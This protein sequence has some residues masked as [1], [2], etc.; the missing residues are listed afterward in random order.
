[1]LIVA[2]LKEEI[3][4]VLSKMQM[5]AI[6]HLKPATLYRGKIFQKEINFLVTGV[7]KNRMEEGLEKAL[8]L[9]QPTSLLCVG[10][11]G[12]ASPLASVGSLVLTKEVMTK[13]QKLFFR[14]D[15]RLLKKA[16]KMAKENNFSFHTGT[17]VTVEKVISNPHEKAD[18]GATH[19]AYALEMEGAFFA[20]KA[21][22]REIP[23]LMVRSILDPVEMVL[24]HL[25]N[26]LDS[27]GEVKPLILAEHCLKN[28][29]EMMQLPK[30]QYLASQAR[31]GLTKFVEGW[32]SHPS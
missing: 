14:S 5:D 18:I 21:V 20:K 3:R 24:P 4:E 2:A 15:N 6:V 26:C 11:A 27:L 31:T 12:G 7:G 19:G 29:K 22:T 17:V 10:F 32:I 16:E 13:D 9:R 23:W 25:E 28:P 1:M 30:M 8:Q